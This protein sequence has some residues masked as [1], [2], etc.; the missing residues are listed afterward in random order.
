MEDASYGAQI[1]TEEVGSSQTN[2]CE[3]ETTPEDDEGNCERSRSGGGAV[4]E[5]EVGYKAGFFIR[6]VLFHEGALV[7]G[8]LDHATLD[9]GGIEQRGA[10][11]GVWGRRA[12]LEV[13]GLGCSRE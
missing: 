2:T 6:T 4:V 1:D 10:L 13:G 12:Y 9:K 3:E 8:L 7:L 11:N 5:L